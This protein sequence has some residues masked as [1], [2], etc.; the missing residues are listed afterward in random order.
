[1]LIPSQLFLKGSNEEYELEE[2]SSSEIEELI[3]QFPQGENPS[4]SCEARVSFWDDKKPQVL[5]VDYNQCERVDEHTL[6][7]K[8][9]PTPE[10]L[11]IFL[12]GGSGYYSNVSFHFLENEQVEPSRVFAQEGI[13]FKKEEGEFLS[14]NRK[15]RVLCSPLKD[16]GLQDELPAF[17]V[18]SVTE[19]NYQLKF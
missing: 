18:F 5:H 15:V 10:N 16:Q 7:L 12:Y 9:F 1:M 19:I 11:I 2:F 17:H 13:F 8:F 6:L 3:H 4:Y 14:L